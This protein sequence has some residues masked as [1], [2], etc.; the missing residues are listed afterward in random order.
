MDTSFIDHRTKVQRVKRFLNVSAKNKR[1]LM[2]RNIYEELKRSG[3][4]NN[5]TME[6]K[7]IKKKM[8]NLNDIQ[9]EQT[10][11]ALMDNKEIEIS[12]E[13][14]RQDNEWNIIN[15]RES[16]RIEAQEYDD[17]LNYIIDELYI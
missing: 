10:Y 1:R 16:S 6:P 12:N 13:L 5:Y 3:Q 8:K 4:I 15:L 11:D 2:R 14:E 7:V 9:L 17:F